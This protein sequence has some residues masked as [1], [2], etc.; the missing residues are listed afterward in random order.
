MDQSDESDLSG[1][2]PTSSKAHPRQGSG[3]PGDDGDREEQC[4]KDLA[5][6]WHDTLMSFPGLSTRYPLADSSEFE[7]GAEAEEL[8]SA[9]APVDGAK[10]AAE[11]D[12]VSEANAGAAAA[13]A[14]LA[15]PDGVDKAEE[16]ASRS[17]RSPPR[18]PNAAASASTQSS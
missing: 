8:N 17:W 16:I 7:E 3:L 5:C 13:A 14:A 12:L 1:G 4:I 6:S 10:V 2:S 9:T 15:A 18:S 11:T